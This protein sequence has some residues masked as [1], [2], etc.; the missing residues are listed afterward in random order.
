M[1]IDIKLHFENEIENFRRWAVTADKRNGEW[2]TDYFYWDVIYD[3]TEK[4][5]KSTAIEDWNEN[6]VKDYLYI[7]ARDNECENIIA[8]LI[9]I[10][11]QLIEL[12][13]LALLCAEPNAKWQIAFGLG[14]IS[15]FEVERKS[16][17]EKFLLDEEEYVRRRASFALFGYG[18]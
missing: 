9:D 6:I 8:Q 7:L 17:L 5:I 16:L 18:R 12:A 10:P 4:L 1:S 2:E 3:L 15:D 11:K 14:E 13:K